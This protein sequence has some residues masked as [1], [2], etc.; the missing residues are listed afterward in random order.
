MPGYP[1]T[2]L[3]TLNSRA[4]PLIL[5]FIKHHRFICS[6]YVAQRARLV[7]FSKTIHFPTAARLES[8]EQGLEKAPS[9]RHRVRPQKGDNNDYVNENGAKKRLHGKEIYCQ[10]HYLS[11]ATKL[12]FILLGELVLLVLGERTLIAFEFITLSY[13]TYANEASEEIEQRAGGSCFI[14]TNYHGEFSTTR[15]FEGSRGD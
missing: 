13:I 7:Q 8:R 15:S 4:I 1:K 11:G 2:N 9:L 6:I 12:S 3:I 14:F 10:I 5:C